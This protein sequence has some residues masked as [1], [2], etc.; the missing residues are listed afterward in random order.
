M[1]VCSH[2]VVRAPAHKHDR[3]VGRTEH[4]SV[5]S[6]NLTRHKPTQV[7]GAAVPLQMPSK[8]LYLED[9]AVA[10]LCS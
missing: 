8:G 7:A 1:P 5:S 2:L 4:L 3:V 9:S 6:L 10:G